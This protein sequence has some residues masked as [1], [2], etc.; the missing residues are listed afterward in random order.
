MRASSFTCTIIL[1][2]S[3]LSSSVS[4]TKNTALATSLL[5]SYGLHLP[6]PV[7]LGNV[8]FT[9]QIL[10][11]LFP[12]NETFLANSTYYSPLYEIPWYVESNISFSPA[13]PL[14]QHRTLIIFQGRK[15]A[16]WSQLAL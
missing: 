2:A 9:C 1:I 8:T 5:D 11:K 7:P 12:R 10:Q 4:V 13:T 15:R 16:G 6:H 14:S 3:V